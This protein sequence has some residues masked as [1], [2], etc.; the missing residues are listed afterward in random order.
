MDTFTTFY[1][2]QNSRNSE[3]RK[4]TVPAVRL[5]VVA[6]TPDEEAA[7][8]FVLLRQLQDSFVA[9]DALQLNDHA[10][11][12]KMMACNG[13]GAAST[14]YFIVDRPRG[15]FDDR[16]LPVADLTVVCMP[17]SAEKEDNCLHAIAATQK[18]RSEYLVLLPL[19]RFGEAQERA[20]EVRNRGVDPVQVGPPLV[21]FDRVT[22]RLDAIIERIVSM[23]LVR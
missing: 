11:P 7:Y 3:S 4:R 10:L 17:P 1:A 12:P 13:S 14:D 19:V 5:L 8:A 16:F 18:T 9:S 22:H 2:A 6:S 23:W 21:P 20:F 15:P